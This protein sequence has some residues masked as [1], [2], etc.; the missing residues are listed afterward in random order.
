[1]RFPWANIALLLLLIIQLITGYWGLVN[2]RSSRAWILWLH[3][4]G[5]YAL[6]VLLYW[7][8]SIITDAI[9]RKT[10]WTRR[11]IGFIFML[12]L[13]LVVLV[14][15]LLWTFMGPIYIGGFSLVSLHIYLAVPLMLLLGWH[16]W[17]M[18]FIWRVP[19]SIGRR[20]FA[21]TSL[22][23]LL[24]LVLWRASDWAKEQL[25][26]PGAARR[27]TGSYEQGSFTPRFPVVSWIADYPPP[28]DLSSWRLQV[29]G[30]VARP[31]TFTY[32][33]LADLSAN[34]VEAILDCTGGWYTAQRWRGV[35]VAGL[36]QQAGV[37]EEAASVTC[38]AVSGYQRRF[39]VA[40]VQSYLLALNVAGEPLS[41]GHGFPVRLVAP[42]QRGVN[43][44]KWIAAVQVN[45]TSKIWQ[46]PLPLQ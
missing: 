26:L 10:V 36:L 19:K 2:G 9:H 29:T 44:V 23:S 12:G 13:L 40:E 24:G 43:W 15:G 42:D 25:T 21:G 37:K 11:R 35:S 32:Q 31:L 1:M 38:R 17:H 8:S 30:A 18:R 27:F 7:K 45:T 14:L 34:E 22:V 39:T 20:L 3:G 6:I 16:A 46:L 5:A 28:V 33:Q 41:H 4:I